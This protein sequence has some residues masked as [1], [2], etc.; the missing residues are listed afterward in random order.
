MDEFHGVWVISQCRCTLFYCVCFITPRRC[1]RV[2]GL[3]LFIYLF[4]GILFFFNGS[5]IA[6]QC[7]AGFCRT[8]TCISHKDAY[9]PSL[10]IISP[11]PHPTPLGLHRAPDWELFYTATSHYQ[12]LLHI[13][14]FY[15]LKVCGNPALSKSTRGIFPTAFTYL[16]SLC[17]IFVNSHNIST[18]SSLLHLLW[19]SVITDLW[20]YCCNCLGAPWTL[21]M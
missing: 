6:L 7:C 12:S 15:K 4:I 5:I 21:L 10:L 17:H 2:V 20:C 13:A 19:W 14:V 3:C 18:F 16:L 9:I 8:T 11:I 1:C